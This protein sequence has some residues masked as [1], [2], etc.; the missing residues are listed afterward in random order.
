[1]GGAPASKHML[2]TAFDIAMTNHDP[3]AFEAAARDVG[4]RG[5][6]TYPRSGFMHVDLGPARRWGEPFPPRVIPFAEEAPMARERLADSRTMKGGGAAGIAT[7]GA[8]GVELAEDI[9]A[10]TQGALQ[11]LIPYL[12]TL[13]WVF[14]ALALA[15]VAVAIYARLDDWKRG[16]R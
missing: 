7:I 14:I 2:G 4:F 8:G 10:E 6:G 11:P 12:D 9:L 13:R 16:R 3:A 5:F 1:M 15:G